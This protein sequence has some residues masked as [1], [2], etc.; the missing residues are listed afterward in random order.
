M[1]AGSA[2]GGGS[3][4]DE[5]SS[6]QAN[7]A[8]AIESMLAASVGPGKAKVTVAADLDFSNTTS[9]KESYE[10]PTTV[11]AGQQLTSD[12]TTKDET[13]G[14][15]A[16]GTTGGVL[17]ATGTP[18]TVA[19][20]G[21]SGYQLKERQVTNALN[22][23]TEQTSKAPG[24]VKR[25]S[26]AVMLDENAMSADKINEVKSLVSAAAGIDTARGDTIAI[27]RL[28][29]DQ[30]VQK[31]MEA[32]LAARKPAAEGLPMAV[33]A[34]G[35][36]GVLV[37]VGLVVM[38]LKKRK[39]EKFTAIQLPDDAPGRDLDLSDRSVTITATP[40][41]SSIDPVTGGVLP[42]GDELAMLSAGQGGGGLARTDERREIL[43]QLIDNQPDEV[44]QLLRSWLGD[45]REVAR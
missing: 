17:G 14:G 40:R 2:L 3:H 7:V 4:G 15:A 29:F 28:P 39:G 31:Q 45:R 42:A 34:G 35:G 21:G 10:P 36:V 26:V 44:A 24:A 37:I 9:T 33:M 22:K 8:G 18:T 30:T 41:Q 43:G 16:A 27:S 19:G 38:L 11:V 5:L 23:V 1:E 12:E 25:L 6:Y 13:Y 32:E 20:A